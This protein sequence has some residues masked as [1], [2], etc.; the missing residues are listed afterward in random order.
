MTNIQPS[1]E[2]E[3]E[4]QEKQNVKPDYSSPLNTSP[5]EQPVVLEAN[6][7]KSSE[8]NDVRPNVDKINS[9]RWLVESI[10]INLLALIV[11]A[12]SLS[13]IVPVLLSSESSN[14]KFFISLLFGIPGILGLLILHR[15][16][17][18]RMA[19][20]VFMIFNIA[21]QFLSFGAISLYAIAISLAVIIF[22]ANHRIKRH[23][24]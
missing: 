13:V 12:Y 11:L 1:D 10:I 22:F 7:A 9:R 19:I 5:I 21:Y 20:V 2:F 17:M 3:K 15:S 4:I 8:Q 24:R 16:D 23:F 14:I 18:A 6:L